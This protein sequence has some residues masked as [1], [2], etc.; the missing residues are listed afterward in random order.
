MLAGF[1]RPHTNRGNLVLRPPSG[2]CTG[3]RS[4]TLVL[5]S[6][7]ELSLNKSRAAPEFF[8]LFVIQG[9]LSNELAHLTCLP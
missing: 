3:P 4:G 1:P 8:A 6:S 9:R 2:L 7:R 5:Q